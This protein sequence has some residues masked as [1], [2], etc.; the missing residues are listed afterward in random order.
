[1][2]EKVVTK[3][4]P[5][6]THDLPKVPTGE[7][8]LPALT[9]SFLNQGLNYYVPAKDAT[10]LKNVV[11]IPS[12][13]D[14]YRA[15]FQSRPFTVLSDAYAIRWR[16]D[17]LT[18]TT[19]QYLFMLMCINKAIDLP[20]YSHK[21][22]LGGWNV[23]KKKSI[24]LP[25]TQEGIDFAFMEEFISTLT[26]SCRKTV[27]AYLEKQGYAN[28]SISETGTA[29][30]NELL[31]A[32]WEKFN[33]RMLFGEATRGKRL[34]SEDR[35]PGE[36]PFV[37]AGETNEGVSAFINNRVEIFSR[38]TTTIDMFGS[39]KY[40]NYEY[41]ADDHIAVVHTER[42]NKHAAIFVTSALNKSAHNGQYHYGRNFYAKDADA[43][44]I[45]LPAKNGLPDYELMSLIVETVEKIVVRHLVIRLSQS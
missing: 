38:N 15:Y 12:N 33:V 45:M 13:S 40:R 3:K 19:N 17:G 21:N 24:L 41:G 29:S 43:L 5:Y 10:L 42:L 32:R 20:I 27:I 39:A 8:V 31:T 35:I 44:E 11:S 9:S 7:Y 16:K 26:K 25:V 34:K 1:M 18:P 4:L 36:L 2:F 14:V 28:H 30:L 6:K 37:T 22:K 23:V